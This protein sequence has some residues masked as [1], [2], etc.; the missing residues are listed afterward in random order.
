[1]AAQ[2]ILIDTS[3][4]IDHL[5]KKNKSNSSLYKI[6]DT[7]QIFISAV[8]LYEL[9]AG[10]TTSE[11]QKDIHDLTNLVII[12]PFD[13]QIAE[14]AG[15]IFQTLRT[16]NK[17]IEIGDIFIGATALVH[18]LPIKILNKKHFQRIKEL[19]VL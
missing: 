8:S 9:F 12:L 13:E 18:D 5:R 3:V 11:K 10:A 7:H 17:L 16:S 2:N 15:E 1:M 4:I 6:I 19:V 14:R